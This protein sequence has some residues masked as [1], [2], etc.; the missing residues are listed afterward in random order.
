M[1]EAAVWIARSSDTRTALKEAKAVLDEL[2]NAL[3]RGD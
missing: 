3:K 1:D 2:L